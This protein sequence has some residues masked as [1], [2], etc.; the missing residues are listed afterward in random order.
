M[1]PR[2]AV[3]RPAGRWTVATMSVPATVRR[4]VPGSL[5][6]TSLADPA[7]SER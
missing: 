1:R 5:R 6:P 3:T 2:P 4:V 7:V